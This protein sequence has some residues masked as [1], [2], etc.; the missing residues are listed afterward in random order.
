MDILD[1]DYAEERRFSQIY[2]VYKSIKQICVRQR[3]LRPKKHY[4][5]IRNKKIGIDYVFRRT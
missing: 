1:A 4:D 2:F 5:T 3:N